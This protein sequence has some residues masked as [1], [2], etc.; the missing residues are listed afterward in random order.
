MG[1]LSVLC[2]K[3]VK[4]T[5]GLSGCKLGKAFNLLKL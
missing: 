1:V 4:E 3:E 5:L 2:L